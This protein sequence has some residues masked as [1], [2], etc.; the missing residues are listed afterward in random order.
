MT[1]QA[2]FALDC[3][4]DG[5]LH[6]IPFDSADLPHYKILHS[7]FLNVPLP[8]GTLPEVSHDGCHTFDWL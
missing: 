8:F 6:F 5:S 7:G 4:P 2:L 3:I 1:S